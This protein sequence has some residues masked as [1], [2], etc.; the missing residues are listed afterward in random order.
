MKLK[1]FSIY[2][3][4]LFVTNF[5][6]AQ[7]TLSGKIVNDDDLE[8]VA[9]VE[10]FNRTLER[11]IQSDANGTF[12]FT[13][14]KPGT[15]RL[16]FLSNNHELATLDVEITNEDKAVDV[17]L[18]PLQE[19]LSPVVIESRR[20]EVFG[21]TRLRDIEGT[22]IY[23]GKKTEVVILDKQMGNMAVNSPRQVFSQVVGLNIYES[24]EGGLQLNIGGRGLDPNR[25]A[26]FNIRQNDYDISADILGYPES[27]YTPPVEG[28][29]RIQIV[30][31]AA[32]LQYGT[33]FGGLINFVMRKP[34]A[35]RK[36]A[37]VTRQTVG[38]FGLLTNF[39]S[40]SGTLGK[41]SYYTYFNYKQ[42]DGFQDNS[43]FKSYNYFGNLNYKFNERTSLSLD[44]TYFD[45]LAQQPGG[46][47]D[48]M[49]LEDPLQS[50][51]K[52][53]WFDVNWNL[54]A[55]K[56]KH[57]VGEKTDLSVNLFGLYA[58][59]KA[60]GFRDNRVSIQDEPGTARD[61]ITGT[62]SNWGFE[63]R[64]LHRYNFFGNE[65]AFVLGTKYYDANNTAQQ[66]PGSSGSGPDFE[67]AT[68]EFPTYSSQSDYTFPNK[69]IAFFGENIFRLSPKFSVTP[70]IRFE[71]INTK[72]EGYYRDITED[73]G[74]NVIFDET[75]FEAND[76]KRSFILMGI[77][78]SYKAFTAAEL[79]ANFSQNY[80]SVT[81]NDIR[82]VEPSQA[83]DENITDEEGFTFDVGIR[84]KV[85]D[86]V[87][88]DVSV[89]ALAYNGRLGQIRFIDENVR[90]VR[91][92][93]NVGDAFIYGAE[94]FGSISLQKAF[95]NP[96]NQSYQWDLFVNTAVTQSEYTKSDENNVEGKQ[97]E[98]I[99][100]VNLKTGMSFGYK[101]FM[102][103]LQFTYISEQFT[104]ATNA[105]SDL[106]DQ[107]GIVGEIPAYHIADLSF[108]YTFTKYLKLETG[109]NNVTDHKYF[110]RRATGYP[111][112]GIIPS[113]PRTYYATL[114]FSL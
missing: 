71:H 93:T 80:R 16:E 109:I 73:L 111:G 10:I 100:L 81:F 1:D 79:Y 38:S 12:T 113:A 68:N 21:L 15:Y 3:F 75:N 114:Q 41:F 86:V 63:A 84:G 104:D 112:P 23:A 25:S 29:D 39:T 27:Y 52:R 11:L 48:R 102:T 85:S 7:Y 96:E 35:D 19:E 31:G 32:S 76:L 57:K 67:L 97:V 110:T 105:A 59:R 55:L 101:K 34:A 22:A 17:K 53:N 24:N 62:F 98:F 83:V 6:F 82:I 88:Y 30:R 90:E 70:G 69:N 18:I 51:R 13:S 92:R 26:H 99:P 40:L 66:G 14:L 9:D 42:G 4:L 54:A 45:Y 8:P 108:S 49:F 56:L 65:N 94:I 44:Y 103:A 91:L 28:L 43:E 5:C 60:V 77:G 95:L 106:R 78:L 36:I 50:N 20:A 107:K 46:L 74:G 87:T 61:L 72:A 2:A 89:F 37:L 64:V 47:T 58:G 33:Q